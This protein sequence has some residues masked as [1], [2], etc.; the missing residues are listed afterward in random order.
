MT[1]EDIFIR[2]CCAV[3]D[4]VGQEKKVNTYGQVIG[5]S[6]A[7]LKRFDTP[8]HGLVTAFTAEAMLRADLGVRAK[9]GNPDTL[10]LCRNGTWNERIVI[11]PVFPCSP[12]SATPKRCFIAVC[13]ISKPG[14]LTQRPYSMPCSPYL[15]LRPRLTLSRSA[16]INFRYN[17]LHHWLNNKKRPPTYM[18]RALESN[19]NWNG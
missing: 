9:K 8:L 11:E 7:T 17:D 5:G 2:I 1:T 18:E 14:L 15:V 4:Q 10:T 19:L 3:A 13:H 16:L 12:L 6:Y